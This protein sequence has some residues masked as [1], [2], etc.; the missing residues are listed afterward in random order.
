M[1]MVWYLNHSDRPNAEL[2]KD[3]YYSKKPITAGEEILIDYNTV[4]DTGKKISFPA[5]QS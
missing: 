2:R 5:T 3:G 4:Y 1:H